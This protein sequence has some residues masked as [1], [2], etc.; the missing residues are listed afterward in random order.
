MATSTVNL[1]ALLEGTK[2][3]LRYMFGDGFKI[4]SEK[5]NMSQQKIAINS[6]INDY[7]QENITESLDEDL[8]S[9]EEESYQRRYTKKK[10]IKKK[11]VHSEMEVPSTPIME[12]NDL[13]IASNPMPT[14]GYSIPNKQQLREAMIWAEVLGEPKCRKKRHRR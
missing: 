1:K 7:Q 12:A 8:Y 10:I 6:D 14:S 11:R 3:E 4:S 5:N 2:E 9:L 13:A